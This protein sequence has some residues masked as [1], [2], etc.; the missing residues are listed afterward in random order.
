MGGFA[1]IP[2]VTARDAVERLEAMRK[3]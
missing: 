3:S 1:G 2:I